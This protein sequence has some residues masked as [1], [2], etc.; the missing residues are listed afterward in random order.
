MTGFA[1]VRSHN[2]LLC[3]RAYQGTQKKIL[4]TLPP[5][6]RD[7]FSIIALIFRKFFEKL[8]WH[9]RGSTYSAIPFKY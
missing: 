3:H 9:A 7:D 6:R 2:Y 1:S 5:P 4:D 8:S